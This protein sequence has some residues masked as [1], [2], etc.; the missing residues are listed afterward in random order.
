VKSLAPSP[1]PDS[2]EKY[3]RIPSPSIATGRYTLPSRRIYP[4]QWNWDSALAALGWAQLDPARAWTEL[5]S[6]AG[7][8]DGDGMVPHRTSAA[9]AVTR[10]PERAFCV[11]TGMKRSMITTAALVVLA[12]T[13]I[14]GVGQ[15]AKPAPS[16]LTIAASDTSV[17]FGAGATLS[18]KLG[19]SNV[20]GRS[21]RVQEDVYPLS[22]FTN[23]GSATT[24]ATGDWSLAVKPTANTRYRAN[25]GK[26]NSPTVDVFVRP[27]ITLKLSDRTPKRGQ[28]VRFAGRLCPEHD[29]VAIE[30]QR[31]TSSGWKK[32]ASPVLAD[33]PGTTCSKYSVRKRVRRSGSYRAHFNADAD[34]A[35]GNSP[36]RRAKVH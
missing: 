6:L 19:G 9:S 18:G 17:K 13:A 11:A 20:S 10:E 21:I 1:R 35:A 5:E 36:R 34:H 3:S 33:V 26:T 8:R 2:G 12:V 28:R 31:K 22:S 16:T 24:N 29:S 7:A 27:A 25:V 15:A 4:H 14:A 23:T 32:V 30:L